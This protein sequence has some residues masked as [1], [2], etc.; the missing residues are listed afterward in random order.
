MP[1]LC[2]TTTRRASYGQQCKP[3]VGHERRRLMR[4]GSVG[5]TRAWAQGKY[6]DVH[7]DGQGRVVGARITNC[8]WAPIRCRT[9][10]T[11]C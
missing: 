10:S 6:I 5:P 7:V 11:E 9:R 8:A 1:R 4:R 3:R 2:A